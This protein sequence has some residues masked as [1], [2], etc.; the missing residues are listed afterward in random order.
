VE[1]SDRW[2]GAFV[3]R[4]NEPRIVLTWHENGNLKSEETLIGDK[5]HGL[6]MEFHENGR[7][8]SRV[9]VRNGL[10]EG[11]YLKWFE[12]GLLEADGNYRHGELEGYWFEYG[13]SGE[14]VREGTYA[15]NKANGAWKEWYRYERMKNGTLR[16][17]QYKDGLRHGKSVEWDT[18]GKKTSE[19]EYKNG[20]MD[21]EWT[22]YYKG[23]VSKTIYENGEYKLQKR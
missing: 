11:R 8:L 6:S 16:E 13:P 17:Y 22:Y 4:S 23:K 2:E 15:A 1:S 19:G 21:G 3:G 7:E 20:R 18:D 12:D 5:E 10:R 14:V 9:T